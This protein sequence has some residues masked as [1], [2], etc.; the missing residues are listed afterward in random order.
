MTAHATTRL[1][2]LAGKIRRVVGDPRLVWHLA[3][4]PVSR[5]LTARRLARSGGR[6][7]FIVGV[8]NSGTTLMR[9]VLEALGYAPLDSALATGGGGA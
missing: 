6:W 2:S 5:L 9:P 8:N 1:R 4:R 7:L 3:P